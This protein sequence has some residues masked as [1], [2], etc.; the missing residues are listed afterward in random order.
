[1]KKEK[2]TL[3]PLKAPPLKHRANHTTTPR[4]RKSF[5]DHVKAAQDRR[6]NNSEYQ[7][8]YL[9]G[10]QAAALAMAK[11]VDAILHKYDHLATYWSFV[12]EGE[13]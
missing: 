12:E 6:L 9:E 2:A 7:R 8:G 4:Q 3:P 5:A 11:V 13:E 1:M 10:E